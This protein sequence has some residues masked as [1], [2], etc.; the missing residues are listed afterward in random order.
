MPK[1]WLSIQQLHTDRYFTFHF[2][3]FY[4]EASTVAQRAHPLEPP[5]KRYLACE[6]GC[7]PRQGYQQ[8]FPPPRPM[9]KNKNIY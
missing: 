8:Y 4:Y 1:Q 9:E 5:E 3:Y 6:E 2:I 7:R